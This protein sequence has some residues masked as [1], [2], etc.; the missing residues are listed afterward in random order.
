MFH[1]Y[2]NKLACVAAKYGCFMR[3][4]VIII[5]SLHT[6]APLGSWY[7][8]INLHLVRT[9]GSACQVCE[10]E[11]RVACSESIVRFDKW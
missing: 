4:N 5:Y 1:R 9:L 8:T 6:L 11:P 10:I 2:L 3:E 7:N